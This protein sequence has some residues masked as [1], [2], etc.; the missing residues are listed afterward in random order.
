MKYEKLVIEKNEFL[1]LKQLLNIEEKQ[2]EATVKNHILKLR[3]E[4]KEAIFLDEKEMYLDVV[5][6]NSLITVS[7][8][9]N[10]WNNTFQLVVPLKSNIA[11]KKVSI[12]M[13]MGAA[14]IGYA[15]GDVIQWEF[16]GGIKRL[17]VLDIQKI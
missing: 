7:S 9:D 6:F 13:P 2:N 11:E 14:V 17:R 8:E 10:D 12:L 15:K 3:E 1:L 16:P 4:L 5:R